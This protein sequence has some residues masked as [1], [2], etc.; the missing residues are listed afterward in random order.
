MRLQE[1]EPH[2]TSLMSAAAL[3]RRGEQ[4]SEEATEPR[5]A[6]SDSQAPL[7]PTKENRGL[8]N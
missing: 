7:I 8:L 6:Q 5:L 2:G 4:G 3:P 1:A